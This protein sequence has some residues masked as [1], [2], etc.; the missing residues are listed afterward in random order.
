MP[1]FSTVYAEFFTVYTVFDANGPE[2]HSFV[3]PGDR[4]LRFSN[5][6]A[7]LV[8]KSAFSRLVLGTKLYQKSSKINYK[9]QIDMK[10]PEF[11]SGEVSSQRQFIFLLIM[12]KEIAFGRCR[13][14]L[15]PLDI[16]ELILGR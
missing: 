8:M 3:I 13:K 16:S 6:K 12:L 14:D 7:H 11:S 9:A 4:K 15:V 2:K 5:C 10:S 1:I